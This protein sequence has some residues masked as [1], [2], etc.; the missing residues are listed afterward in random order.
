VGLCL[1]I[2]QSGV[3]EVAEELG[4]GMCEDGRRWEYWK[5]VSL[6][7]GGV[8]GHLLRIEAGFRIIMK[9]QSLNRLEL[10]A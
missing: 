9:L 7:G 6:R 4:A 5:M 8:V 10:F 3:G 1:A 2:T